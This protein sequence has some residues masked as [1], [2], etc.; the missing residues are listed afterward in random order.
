MM[1][2]FFFFFVLH[3]EQIFYYRKNEIIGDYPRV[4]FLFSS[5]SLFV[6]G[7]FCFNTNLK[8]LAQ[9]LF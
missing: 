3:K 9:L 1:I 2:H 8:L 5:L 4:F 7:C 6:F